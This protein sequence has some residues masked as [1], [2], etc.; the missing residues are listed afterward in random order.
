MLLMCT[1]TL[2]GDT[3]SYAVLQ[4]HSTSTLEQQVELKSYY[5]SFKIFPRF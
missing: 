2:G 3:L 4:D 5:Y 1:T